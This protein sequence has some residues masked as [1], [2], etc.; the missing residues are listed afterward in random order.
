MSK[1][2]DAMNAFLTN[3]L[4]KLKILLFK[5]K[6]IPLQPRYKPQHG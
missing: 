3:Q 2:Q 6:S 5:R 1:S 4:T